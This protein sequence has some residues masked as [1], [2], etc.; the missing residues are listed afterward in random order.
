MGWT[1]NL[2]WKT[3]CTFRDHCALEG[4][5][6]LYNLEDNAVQR[7][8]CCFFSDAHKTHKFTAWQNLEILKF[9]LVLPTETTEF[10][11]LK[12][13]NKSQKFNAV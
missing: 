2:E 5:S 3:G 4:K 13:G 10:R 9:Q 11:G 1:L 6:G 8:N 12:L 7:N